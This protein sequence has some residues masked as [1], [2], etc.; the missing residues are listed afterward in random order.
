MIESW[1]ITLD[2]ESDRFR[3][4][5][6][7]NAHLDFNVFDGIDG[8]QLDY[9]DSVRRGF[10]TA[11]CAASGLVTKGALGCAISHWTL[12]WKAIY[13]QKT[14]LILEDDAVT[15]C[16]I[17]TWIGQS[18]LCRDAD[19]VLFGINTDSVLEAISPKGV[20]QASIFG[21][22][23]PDYESIAGK[24]ALTK[25]AD[26]RPWRLLAG[27]GQC[28]CLVTPSGAA[29]LVETVLPLRLDEISLPLMPNPISG[30][31]IDRRLN[32]LYAEIEAYVAMP[33]LAWTPNTD[34]TTR[35]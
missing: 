33:F 27:F 12:W 28:C 13:E 31:G 35:G 20:H 7:L 2:R 3:R 8:A 10:L 18:D 6:E 19:L 23:N 25:P 32:A 1:V 14:L 16:D 5:A 15:H 34:S 21:E 22:T 4:F 9:P 17:R 26:V 30:T 11:E 29:R 24:L